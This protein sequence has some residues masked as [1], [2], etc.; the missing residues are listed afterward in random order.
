MAVLHVGMTKDTNEF[1]MVKV[2][3]TAAID[4]KC[5]LTGTMGQRKPRSEILSGKM[6]KQFSRIKAPVLVGDIFNGNFCKIQ[7]LELKHC[8]I[9]GLLTGI[10]MVVPSNFAKFYSC[11]LISPQN[12]YSLLCSMGYVEGWLTATLELIS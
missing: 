1:L 6:R 11:T 10:Q 9:Y 8:L 4:S 3:V 7:Q 2:G 5:L 12:P